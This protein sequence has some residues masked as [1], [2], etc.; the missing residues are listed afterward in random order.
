MSKHEVFHFPDTVKL[1]RKWLLRVPVRDC[2]ELR[3]AFCLFDIDGD[4]K[5]TTDELGT[6]MKSLG[7]NPSADQLREMIDEVDI[8]GQSASSRHSAYLRISS[9]FDAFQRRVSASFAAAQ[10]GIGLNT[11]VRMLDVNAKTLIL[12]L[13]LLLLIIIMCFTT[14]VNSCKYGHWTTGTG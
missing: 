2:A 5:I 3:E 11:C 1:L 9:I 8:D 13:L 12:R 4:G 14:V 6:V 7:M 10:W